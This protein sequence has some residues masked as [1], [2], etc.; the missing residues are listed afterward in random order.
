MQENEQESDQEACHQE[1]WFFCITLYTV[2][3]LIFMK[4]VVFVISLL[5][6]FFVFFLKYVGVRSQCTMILFNNE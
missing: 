1:V 4:E 3:L 2:S 5:G 6:F